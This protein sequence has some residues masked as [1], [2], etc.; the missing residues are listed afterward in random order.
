MAQLKV[1]PSPPAPARRRG[2]PG[3]DRERLLEIAARTFN[4]RGYDATSMEDLSAAL[5]ISKSAIY[6]HVAGKHQLL[7]LAVDRALD[8][9][10]E[11]TREREAT[12]GPAADR[13][14]HVL[15]RSVEVLVAELPY[16][17]LLLRL[18]GNTPVERAALE[19]RRE[20]DR[21]VASLVAD[22]EAEGAVRPEIDPGLASR[23]LFG[24]VN[25]IIEWYRPGHGDDAALADTVVHL[26]FDGL[27]RRPAA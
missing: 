12:H 16:V 26:C 6:H 10:F 7:R 20:F 22:A 17:T 9:L 13:L 1:N 2:R 5:G 4:R 3:Y 8:G 27:S 21:V 23:L 24:M 11:V 25:S 19:R 18:R 15:R 14:R